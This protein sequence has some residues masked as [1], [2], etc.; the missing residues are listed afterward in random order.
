MTQTI[1]ETDPA[2]TIRRDK[3]IG[4][5][6]QRVEDKRYLTGTAEYV[7]DLKI[8][9]MLYAIYVRS[10]YPHARI[11]KVDKSV[12]EQIH[13]SVRVFSGADFTDVEPLIDHVVLDDL[14][15][16]PQHVVVRDKAR[17]VGDAVA[18]VVAETDL[19]AADAAAALAAAIE[20]EVLEPV[21]EVAGDTQTSPTIHDDLGTNEIYRKTERHGDSEASFAKADLVVTST[22]HHN[23]YGAAPMET[24]G[25]LANF[26]RAEN[27]LTVWSS[28]QMPHFLRSVIAGQL[29][30]SE[31]RIRVIAPQV[32]GGFGQKMATSPEEIAIP[33]VAWVL[34]K[35]VRWIEDRREHLIAATQA[36]EQFIRLEA[37]VTKEGRI[38][39]VRGEFVGDGGGYSFNTESALIEPALAGK[40]FPGP[41]R[42]EA[43]D[44]TVAAS[45]T[46]KSPVAAYRGVGWTAANT[47]REIL[48]DDIARKLGMDPV[49]I[50]RINLLHGEELPYRST[51]G[52]LYDSG[53]YH[54]SL[55]MAVDKIGY[56]D[57]RERQ[58]ELRKDGRYIGIGISSYVE[59]T[60][61]GSESSAQA[62]TPLPSHDNA[63]VTM[64]PSGT[65]LIAVSTS[66]HGQGHETS[67]AQI[68]A[69]GLGID[70]ADIKVIDGDTES[71]PYGLGTYASRSAVIGGACVARA[72]ADV[73]AQILRAAANMMEVNPED[74]TIVDGEAQVIGAPSVSRPLSEVAYAAHWDAEVRS[75][76]PMLTSTKFYDPPAT[77]ANGCV[78]IELEVDIDTGQIQLQRIVAIEDCGMQINPM[79][80]EAQVHG[81]IAQGVGGALY[82]HFKF[83]KDGTPLSTSYLEYQIPSAAD[84]PPIEVHSIE[85]PSPFSVGGIKGMGEGG[86]ISAPAAVANAVANALE[87]FGVTVTKLPLDPDYV[88]SLIHGVDGW[89]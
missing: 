65:V 23:R 40:A 79:I 13:A 80:V 84:M 20:Y 67:Y 1:K 29:G 44:E 48:V 63:T 75:E 56:E 12:A 41:Y 25:V 2:L 8:P 24:R 21:L 60:A 88:L 33:Y 51:T 34:G 10:P 5:R 30:M 45:L 46:N 37:A 76:N 89:D 78:A 7:A 53:S 68:A 85:T 69:D 42:L 70:I 55:D 3:W 38:L 83:A 54:E 19:I 82:E 77:Y 36:K 15:R 71:S 35:P 16:T 11:I 52:Q 86:Q 31:N 22:L 59:Q 43:F 62:G 47:A 17:F 9:G 73:R 32:G 64:D 28:T 50:R 39:A 18:I 14:L 72:A 4:R 74:L 57:F 26:E 66:C 87:P 6:T 27:Q 58:A 49:E 61:W 81:A